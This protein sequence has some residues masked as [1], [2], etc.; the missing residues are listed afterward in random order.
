MRFCS[1]PTAGDACTA[2]SWIG[3]APAFVVLV[4]LAASLPIPLPTPFRRFYRLVR[5]R[6]NP[7]LTLREAEGL[8][9]ASA[10]S[11]TSPEP[12]WRPLLFAFAGLSECLTWMADASFHFVVTPSNAWGGVCR[13][14]I[15]FSWMYTTVR[16]IT[17]PSPTVP[18]D[19][20]TI[21]VLHFI[22]GFLQI[23]GYLFEYSVSSTPLP[24][25]LVLFGLSANLA[26]VT[27]LLYVAMRMPIAL[28]SAQVKKED[29]GYTISPEDYTSL[30]GWLTFNW[31]YPLIERGTST[32]L[33]E[34][35]VWVLS[36]TNQSRLIFLKF[37]RNTGSTLLRRIWEANSLDI[38]L[39]FFGTLGSVVFAY[40]GPYFLKRLLDAIDHPD[41]T[42]RDKGMAYQFAGLIFICSILKAQFD[43]Q[44]LWYGQ[45]AATRIRSEL[46]A[47]IY[48]KALK[49]KD[50]SGIIDKERVQHVADKK[51]V[52]ESGDSAAEA[53]SKQA[54]V[55]ENEPTAGADI[56]KIVNLMSGDAERIATI[57]SS[58]YS[59]Y[60]APLE[61]TI[62]FVFLYQLL[63][64]TAFSGFIVILAGIPLNN[65]LGWRN[66]K[67]N[68]GILTAKDRR[69]GEV[70]ELLGAIKFV[71]YFSWEELWIGRAMEAR[72]EEMAW[73]LKGRLNN[74]LFQCVWSITPIMLSIISFFTYVWMGNTLTIAKAF[75][76][77]ALFAMIRIP[78]NIAPMYLV[79][80]I[81]A[82]IALDRIAVFLGEAEV[83]EQVSALKVDFSEP[84]LAASE[85][86]DLGLENASFKWNEVGSKGVDVAD[87]ATVSDY[88][89]SGNLSDD[90]R[91]ELRD[92]SVLFPRDVLT[93][94]T[95][96]TASGKTALLM[97][98][99]GEM[100]LLPGGRII[101][102]KNASNVDEHGN[103]HTISYA[104]QKPW[105]RHES[106]KDNI[107]FGYPFDEQRYR[108]VLECCA[109]NP[110]LEMLEDGD[111]TEIGAQGISLSGGQKARVALARACYARTKWVLLDDPLSAVDSHTARFLYDRLLCGPL[112]ANR[113][114]VLVTHHIHLVLP[115]AQYLIV[116]KD[117]RIDSQG[118]VTD[119]R[120]QGVLEEIAD[121]EA[122]EVKDEEPEPT[123]DAEITDERVKKL[124]SPRKLVEDEHRATGSVKWSVYN[125][126]LAAAEYWVCCF[127]VVLVFVVQLKG[128]GEKIWIKI[129]GEAYGDTGLID[130]SAVHMYSSLGGAVASPHPLA[131]HTS[132]H[133]LYFSGWP[134][135]VEQPLYYA[136][137][138][139]AI[140]LFGVTVHL[141]S[142]AMEHTGA[143][144]ASHT[145]YR[146]L[147]DSVVRATFRFHDT[148]PQ[149]RML[150]RFGRDMEIIDNQIVWSMTAL[151]NAL[152]GFIV[153]V[154]TVLVVFPLF[155]VPA[156]II[157]YFYRVLA[158][159]YLNTGRDLR[160]ME[161]NSR[162]PIFSDFAA[163]LDGIV[164]VRAFS[165]EKRLMNKLHER[166]DAS[167]QLWYA[168]WMTNRWLLLNFDFLGSIS[169]FATACFAIAFLD[170]DAGLAGLAITSAL[171]FSQGVYQTLRFWTTLELDLNCV[172]RIVEYLDL[173]QEPP[174]VIESYRPPAYWPSTSSRGALITV[175]DLVIKYAPDL[176][177]V[178]R[179]VSFSLNAG[180]RVGLVGRTGSGKSTL[181]TSFLRFV[182]PSSGRILI[183]GIDISKI[184]LHDLRSRITFIPQD[185][186][187]FSGTLR[188]NLDPFGE[189]EDSACMSVLYRVH[190]ISQSESA[191]H[192]ATP[193]STRPPSVAEDDSTSVADTAIDNKTTI[194]LD[195]QVSAGGAN[196]S[197]GQR[198]LI[199]LARALLRRSA[200][201]ILDEPTS[202]VDFETDAKIQ[203][204]IREEF[205]GCL[206][207][208]IAHRLRTIMD[209]DRLIV[210]DQGKVVEMDTPLRLMNKDSGIFRTMC[211]TSGSYRELEAIAQ[212]TEDA[213]AEF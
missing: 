186:A 59:L 16:P 74:V 196:F 143:L 13:L 153:S 193:Y 6:L 192:V 161:S 138:Y 137:I 128:V 156:T 182:D 69:M 117:G 46:M 68:K 150:N 81:Q 48:D 190:L 12:R 106:I 84:V 199:S 49:R 132:V 155:I 97:A 208:T 17:R 101:M 21:Y 197:Q 83:S 123:I 33:D 108:D 22:A 61:F 176:P 185:A 136:G 36:P 102:S 191:S 25:P 88:V 85:Q 30:I 79:E 91:F 213:A 90:H 104:A 57:V 212:A 148:T 172:E 105:L 3:I 110:D 15:A 139:A 8:D 146:R 60:G 34:K 154:L 177:P 116:M 118:T 53:T 11:A 131:S 18:Y 4:I 2:G 80:M 175:E 58:M 206:L 180:E 51:K 165:A 72:N 120:T 188:D 93:V 55:D 111:A 183:D 157:G 202:S 198:Q 87:D 173:P 32:R 75:T 178:L 1:T 113:T 31:V 130:A 171:N 107:L 207:L 47:A 133:D 26:V 168:F 40:S 99:L 78:L 158:R 109:L 189:Y 114:V 44:H 167:T 29:I 20:F 166:L 209:Y 210:L 98:V 77:L 179:G 181:A 64:W 7:Y 35:D 129:W 184:G 54:K 43:A 121:E 126:Y 50:F 96:P 70:N 163:L 164:T 169:V 200:L 124:K 38:S 134:S 140:G 73:R 174:A 103:M 151:S 194:S 204:T 205:S 115:G 125:T 62:G 127:F 56:G 67:I 119:L 86:S 52:A 14:L 95:G 145:I 195:T 19:L 211:L 142:V 65:Y 27:T 187:L 39:D 135:A 5:S 89:H 24:A 10:P 9:L 147:L 170:D 100:T 203:A 28:P 159:G 152:G 160:R 149:G 42:N 45:R 144:N 82:R 41:K 112:L 92:V 201:I 66:A 94:V 71:K 141:L 76:A 37:Q 63:G 122:M 23:G 162:S